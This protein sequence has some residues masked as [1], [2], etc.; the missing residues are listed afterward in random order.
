VLRPLPYGDPERLVAIWMSNRDRNQPFVEFSYPAYR[1]WRNRSR[2][3]EAVAAMSSVNDEN[4]SDGR[5]RSD[6]V[7]GRWVTGDFF[8]VLGVAPAFGRALAPDDDRPVCPQWSSSSDRFWRDRLSAGDATSWASPMTLDGK[9]HTIVGVMP[10]DLRI[11]GGRCIG[12]RVA[13]A[14]GDQLIEKSQHFLDGRPR[15]AASWCR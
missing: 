15:P 14:G 11:Q 10:P 9:P 12:P 6:V 8:S 1:E 3:L 5:G 2:Q 4:D 7:E 13:P